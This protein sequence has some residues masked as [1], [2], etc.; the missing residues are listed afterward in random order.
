MDDNFIEMLDIAKSILT[1]ILPVI[2]AFFGMKIQSSIDNKKDTK[3]YIRKKKE[4]EIDELKNYFK[5]FMKYYKG[6]IARQGG[7]NFVIDN[8]MTHDEFSK[9]TSNKRYDDFDLE[10]MMLIQRLYFK[11][12]DFERL[13]GYILELT[14]I[15]MQNLTIN[16]FD[17]YKKKCLIVINDCNDHQRE[18][19]DLI[20]SKK[21]ELLLTK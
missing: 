1:Y 13:Q 9:L 19:I 6:I 15:W 21:N 18:I 20:N 12:R 8:Q 4:E 5:N 11:T 7:Y 17:D 14:Q 10:Y 2:T 16:N 3:N